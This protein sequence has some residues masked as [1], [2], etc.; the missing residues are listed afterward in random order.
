MNILAIM[1]MPVFCCSMETSSLQYVNPVK[2]YVTKKPVP[3]V[4]ENSNN[5]SRQQ[6]ILLAQ[7]YYPYYGYN[8]YYYG[9]NPHYNQQYYRQQLMYLHQLRMQQMRNFRQQNL[10]NWYRRQRNNDA[11]HKRYME[12]IRR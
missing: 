7:G 1:L 9:Y 6:R 8:P 4:N 3:G 12:S 10:N 11:A 2:A 5:S